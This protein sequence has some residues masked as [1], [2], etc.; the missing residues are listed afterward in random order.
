MLYNNTASI[1]YLQFDRINTKPT[2]INIQSPI[3]ASSITFSDYQG[4][5]EKLDY[6]DY[7]VSTH[8][9]NVLAPS[10]TSESVLRTV[11]IPN[12]KFSN[13]VGISRFIYYRLEQNASSANNKT[14]KLYVNS[15]GSLTG[16]TVIST[17]TRTTNAQSVFAGVLFFVSAS[18]PFYLDNTV[19]WN[20]SNKIAIPYDTVSSSLWLISTVQK[21]SAAETVREHYAF[22]IGNTSNTVIGEPIAP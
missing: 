2:S 14:W 21:A 9:T 17:V 4:T 11:E 1:N 6:I 3:T 10:T 7:T 20:A 5:I 13:S 18:S 16:A 15:T 22:I 8:N 12:N 19:A